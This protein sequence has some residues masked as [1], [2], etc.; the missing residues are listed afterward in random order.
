MPRERLIIHH[1]STDHL[2]PQ[3]NQFVKGELGWEQIY[4]P[5]LCPDISPTKY[6][7]F[8]YLQYAIQ[9]KVL[10]K[11]IEVED[12]VSKFFDNRLKKAEFYRK[13]VDE[14]PIRW[15]KIVERQGAYIETN[16]KEAR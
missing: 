9:M 10:T 5:K 15:V 4:H 2:S 14:W 6:C 1:N 16:E 11:I 12:V 13:A 3:I 7:I 8:Q